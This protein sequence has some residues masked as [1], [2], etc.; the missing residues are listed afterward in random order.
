M[1]VGFEMDSTLYSFDL[2][3]VS[4]T[5]VP[6]PAAMGLLGLLGLLGVAVPGLLTRRRKEE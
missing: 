6:E 2:D 4:V 3:K 1:P 5:T